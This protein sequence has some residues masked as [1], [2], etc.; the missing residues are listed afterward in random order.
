MVVKSLQESG[1]R[2]KGEKYVPGLGGASVRKDKTGA[3][4]KMHLDLRNRALPRGENQGET[5]NGLRILKLGL[6]SEQEEELII[7]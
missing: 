7:S 4:K 6:G 3:V 5:L 1:L 2:G